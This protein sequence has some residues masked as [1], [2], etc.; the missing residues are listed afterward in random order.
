[1]TDA[2]SLDARVARRP[3]GAPGDAMITVVRALTRGQVAVVVAACVAGA[4]LVGAVGLGGVVI[5]PALLLARACTPEVGIVSLFVAF[6]PT[7][8]LR[9]WML[10]KIVPR[11]RFPTRL[12]GVAAAGGACGASVAGGALLDVVPREALT[13]VIGLVALVAGG[14]DVADSARRLRSRAARSRAGEGETVVTV[15]DGGDDGDD[16][17]A[18]LEMDGADAVDANE[19]ESKSDEYWLEPTTREMWLLFSIGVV[20]GMLS[21]LTGTG[22]PISFLPIVV[23]WK[24]K[25]NR[26]VMLSMSAIQSV[27]LG[28]AAIVSTTA[29]GKKPDPGLVL[30]I[31]PCG[32]V[33]VALGVRVLK[34]FSREWLTLFIGTILLAVGSFTVHQ[35][36]EL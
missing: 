5:L 31:L 29:R 32:L 23:L 11:D 17:D 26:K 10:R 19:S 16:G 25:V 36:T 4:L 15:E 13:Y 27:F 9:V 33:G 8:A 12:G 34:Y 28:I 22:G 14:K 30:L 18:A 24:G 6:T 7:M 3:R 35:A 21:V 20:V 1:M 2:P